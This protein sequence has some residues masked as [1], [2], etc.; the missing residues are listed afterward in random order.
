MADVVKSMSHAMAKAME[1]D[2]K[3][4]PINISS[5]E[6]AFFGNANALSDEQAEWAWQQHMVDNAPHSIAE[7]Q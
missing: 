6:D 1:S 2:E 5:G 4:Y 3:C 7:V